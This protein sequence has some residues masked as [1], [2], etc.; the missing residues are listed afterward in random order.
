MSMRGKIAAVAAVVMALMTGLGW[1]QSL[2][3]SEIT[4]SSFISHELGAFSVLLNP[5]GLGAFPHDDGVMVYDFVDDEARHRQFAFALSMGSLGFGVQQF[6][7]EDLSEYPFLRIYRANLSVGGRVLSIGTSNKLYHLEYPHHFARTFSIDAG[8]HFQ[9]FKYL[10]LAGL[11]LDCNEPELAE[12]HIGRRYLIGAAIVLF[13]RGLYLQQQIEF[14]DDT[15]HI[16]DVHYQ[17]GVALRPW[18]RLEFALGYKK[19]VFRK[20]NYLARI[21][22]PLPIGVEV[23][24]FARGDEKLKPQIFAAGLLLPLQPLRF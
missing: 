9:P 12:Y 4:A 11:A 14:S 1:S 5:A 17:F 24:A 8:V 22:V 3:E 10:Q 18:G 7:W 20:E 2:P 23:S 6:R 15:R 19:E 13:D 16:E 21:K